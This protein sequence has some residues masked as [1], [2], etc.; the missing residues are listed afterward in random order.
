MKHKIFL[1]DLQFAIRHSVDQDGTASE[2]CNTPIMKKWEML[3]RMTIGNPR[4]AENSESAGLQ[5][6]KQI[7]ERQLGGR[8]N[9]LEYLARNNEI[10]RLRRS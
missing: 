2:I 10:V 9:V 1:Y 7:I 6:A 3:F 4:H 5:Q 8:R